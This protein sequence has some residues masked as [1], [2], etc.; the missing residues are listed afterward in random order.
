MSGM[1]LF[2]D[3]AVTAGFALRF[4]V[5][6]VSPSPDGASLTDVRVV[7]SFLLGAQI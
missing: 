4:Y 2:G 7:P 1:K 5:P 3:L 6:G